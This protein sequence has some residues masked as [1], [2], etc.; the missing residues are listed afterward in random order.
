MERIQKHSLAK[1]KQSY[2]F[3]MKIAAGV[4]AGDAQRYGTYGWVERLVRVDTIHFLMNGG[5]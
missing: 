5:L 4:A 1:T 3:A 2:V